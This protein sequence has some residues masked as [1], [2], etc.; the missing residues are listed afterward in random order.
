MRDGEPAR[1][2]GA[3]AAAA[4]VPWKME[5]ADC[6]YDWA[7]RK[8]GFSLPAIRVASSEGQRQRYLWDKAFAHTFHDRLEAYLKAVK[9][10]GSRSDCSRS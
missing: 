2:P 9:D 7:Y 6:P 10:R 5:D 8:L 4:G 1:T 3:G